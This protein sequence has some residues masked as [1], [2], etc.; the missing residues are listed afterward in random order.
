MCD[1]PVPVFVAAVL[2]MRAGVT[3]VMAILS[4]GVLDIRVCGF[5]LL[6]LL[7]AWFVLLLI[8]ERNQIA[9]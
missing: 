2:G 9:S 1:M 5:L 3:V 6:L 7:F 8:K 4:L